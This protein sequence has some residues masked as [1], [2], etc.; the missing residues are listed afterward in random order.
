VV[1]YIQR[2]RQ[3]RRDVENSESIDISRQQIEKKK[4]VNFLGSF[5]ILIGLEVTYII[6]FAAIYYTV[7]QIVITVMSTLFKKTYHLSDLSIGLTFLG[8]GGGSIIGTLVAGKVLDYD[9]AKVKN[10]Y[11]GAVEDFPL[12]RAR[13][14]TVWF[15]SGLQCASVLVF[16]WTL[17]Y[18]IHISVPIICTFIMGWT[19]TSI[20][21]IISTLVV[22]I[23]PRDAASATAAINLLRCLMAAGSIAAAL[24]VVNAIGS[25]WTF[26][27]LTAWLVASLGLIF[28]QLGHGRRKRLRRE[29]RERDS[30]ER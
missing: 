27:I 28:L 21:S 17:H 12:E 13:L 6:I 15:Y 23:F 30:A 14:R 3:K 5:Q 16:G 20:I 2:Y 24:P 4:P 7:W 9:Y 25:G 11:T 26:T 10:S 8:N 22:D 19:A 29:Q 18:K 1:S